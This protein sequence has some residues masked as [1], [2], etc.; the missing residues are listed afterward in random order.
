L[1]E[2]LAI[3]VEGQPQEKIK[4]EIHVYLKQKY[5]RSF[6]KNNIIFQKKLPSNDNTKLDRK[7]ALSIFSNNIFQETYK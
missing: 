1:G 4:E 5:Q 2:D 6:S 7:K 3:L